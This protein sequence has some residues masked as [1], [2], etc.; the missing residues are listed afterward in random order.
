MKKINS[1]YKI[2]FSWQMVLCALFGIFIELTVFQI[3]K[4]EF[5]EISEPNLIFWFME[6][7]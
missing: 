7:D 4:M 2:L 5:T 1:L 3:S 6:A